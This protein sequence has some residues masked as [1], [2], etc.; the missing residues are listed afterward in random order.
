MGFDDSINANL[1]DFAERQDVE[2]P[3]ELPLMAVRDVVVFNSMIIPLFVGRVSSV[4]AVNE[5]LT[6]DKLLVLLTQRARGRQGPGRSGRRRG[7]GGSQGSAGRCAR[8]VPA[9]DRDERR[10]ARRQ[11]Q[12]GGKRG[13]ERGWGGGRAPATVAVVMGR[14]LMIRL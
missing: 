13:G 2:I 5:A 7:S 4:A 11:Q 9:S 10:R 14:S 1:D 8:G 6:R 3:D 12:R